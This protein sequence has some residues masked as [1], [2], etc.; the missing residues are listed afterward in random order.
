MI[1]ADEFDEAAHAKFEQENQG[2][3]VEALVWM[4]NQSGKDEK[5]DKFSTAQRMANTVPKC[6]ANMSN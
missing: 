6:N 4:K 2:T 3:D 1:I 5:A